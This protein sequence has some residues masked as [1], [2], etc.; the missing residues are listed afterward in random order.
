VSRGS[1]TAVS[2]PRAPF[3]FTNPAFTGITI[4]QSRNPVMERSAPIIQK[5]RLDDLET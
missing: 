2:T 4:P 1:G 3:P 5:G